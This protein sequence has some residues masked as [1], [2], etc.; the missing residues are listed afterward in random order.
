MASHL[1][2]GKKIFDLLPT[3]TTQL[4]S[5]HL[6]NSGNE[7]IFLEFID[8]GGSDTTLN[9]GN[10]IQPLEVEDGLMD[11]SNNN[12][13]TLPVPESCDVIE[14]VNIVTN[15]DDSIG[16][17]TV[18]KWVSSDCG[19]DLEGLVPYG[20][21]SD[22]E[23]DSD[24]FPEKTNKRKKRSQVQKSHWFAEKNRTS[25]EHGKKYYGRKKTE[26][27][28]YE[29]PR[30]PRKMGERCKCKKTVKG[31]LKCAEVTE[32]N[33][34]TIFKKFWKMNW[35][36]K[37]VYVCH[38]VI[39]SSIKRPRARKTAGES[40]RA[41]SFTYQL[42]IGENL[43]KVCRTLFLNTLG[44]GRWTIL[45]WKNKEQMP[46]P[47]TNVQNRSNSI[48]TSKPFAKQRQGLKNFFE[49][50]PVLDS[51]YC[52]ATT[53]KKYLLPEWSSKQ[54][55]YEF[56]VKDWCQNQN[57]V[58]LSIAVFYEMFDAKNLGLF[59]P[60][61]DQCEKCAM[62]KVGKVSEA[63]ISIHL[64]KKDEAR[65]EKAKDKEK[66]NIL[67]L[68]VDLQSVL[69]APKSKVS[70]L[71]YRTKL[72]VH[73]FTFYNLQTR[74]GFC[75]LWN[76]TEGGLSSEEFATIWLDFIAKYCVQE[77]QK[78]VEKI[79]FYSDGCTYQNRNSI[80]SNALLGAAT[81]HNLTIEQKYLEV[82]HTQMEGDSMH[83]A[84]ERA[85]KNRDINVPAEYIE[86]CKLAR[87]KPSPYKV[88][89]L[90]HE[91]FRKFDDVQF[92]K[93]IRPGRGKGD[94]KVTDMRAIQY[95]PNGDIHFKLYFTEEWKTL[96][97]RK[98]V[99]VKPILLTELPNL[100][101][102]KKK[103]SAKKFEDLQYLKNTLPEDYRQFYENLD[104]E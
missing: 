60:R 27:W 31:T 67:V 89:Y 77:D 10:I 75:F 85:L 71:Y 102:T 26:C 3:P 103:I 58:P 94:A 90:N 44:I 2:R 25:R 1:W 13:I 86:I 82:G 47:N 21:H 20:F 79:I 33:R 59:F 9:L 68:S 48:T 73:N 49:S 65:A 83:S 97:Q 8:E 74:D 17:S 45:H 54:S 18:D 6:S 16:K 12:I 41:Q 36:E 34:A 15:P 62:Y 99:P 46:E 38:L 51:H 32:E 56:Y 19:S 92:Y 61:K 37:K 55:L 93:S 7:D 84:I 5:Q 43:I 53:K 14:V 64:K 52:R 76:E 4:S 81:K 104:H 24:H 87:K 100:H 72:Q 57:Y 50:L 80:L 63:E 69:M 66:E 35:C 95:N 30:E 23:S 88:T 29:I 42:K 39:S 28:N 70:S 101:R 11:I 98:S 91:F 22:S 96:P 78:L 40:R